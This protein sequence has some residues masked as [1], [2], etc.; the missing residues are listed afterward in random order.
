MFIISIRESESKIKDNSA[1]WA[2]GRADLLVFRARGH[3]K[4]L[5]PDLPIPISPTKKVL[6]YALKMEV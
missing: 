4:C 3:Y 1:S 5:S 6:F 2:Q